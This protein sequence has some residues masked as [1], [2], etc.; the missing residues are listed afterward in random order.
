MD[1]RGRTPPRGRHT[2]KP[3]PAGH[4]LPH[5]RPRALRRDEPA[6][7]TYHHGER[8]RELLRRGLERHG[9]AT[10]RQLADKLGIPHGPGLLTAIGYRGNA[11]AAWQDLAPELAG[12]PDQ[13]APSP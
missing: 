5:P 13:P 8:A 3:G 4:R 2:T 1:K 12:E 6:P 10:T 7:G 9:C 11:L